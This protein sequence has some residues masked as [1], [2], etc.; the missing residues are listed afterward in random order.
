M[1]LLKFKDTGL[2][3]YVEMPHSILIF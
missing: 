3:Y 2:I 1:R